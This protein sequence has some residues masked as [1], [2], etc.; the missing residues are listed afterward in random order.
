MGFQDVVPEQEPVIL[1]QRTNLFYV[2]CMVQ[3]KTCLTVI[4]IGSCANVVFAGLV[5]KLG[6]QV[7][8]HLKPYALH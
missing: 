2:Q 1:D 8:Q 6:L 5:V 4:D 7:E 3:G